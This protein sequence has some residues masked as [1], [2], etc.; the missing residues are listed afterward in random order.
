MRILVT[1]GAGFIGQHVVAQLVTTAERVVVLDSLRPDVHREAE[2]AHGRL[3]AIG[4]DL[5]IGDVRD[6]SAVAAALS[7]IDVVVH[8][9]AKV[10]LGISINDMPDYVSTND[11]GTAVLFRA[12]AAAEIGSFVQASSMVVYGEGRYICEV[13]GAVAPGARKREALSQG[14]FEPPCPA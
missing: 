5:V 7:G 9:A 10:G 4:A 14:R 6:E 12:V 2:S 13:H 1:G 11:H 8:L 3:S